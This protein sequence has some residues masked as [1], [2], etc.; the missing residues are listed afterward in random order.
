MEFL[1]T[2]AN[3]LYTFGGSNYTLC[4][5]NEVKSLNLSNP[6]HWRGQS[7]LGEYR[8]SFSSVVFNNTIYALGGVYRSFFEYSNP[9]IL[10][11]CERYD[12]RLNRWSFVTPMNVA[13]SSAAAA[14][15]G[16][17]IYVAGG[18]GIIKYKSLR[19]VERYDPQLDTWSEVAPMGTVRS[20]FA[21][22]AFAGRL[23]AT[24]GWD[25]LKE[26]STVESYDPV[27][28]SWQ[29]EA[30]LR[31][32][33]YGHSAID[34]YGELFVV[35]GCTNGYIFLKSVQ[36]T[37]KFVPSVGWVNSGK[38]QSGIIDSK[39]IMAYSSDIPQLLS[40]AYY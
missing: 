25:G 35:G 24:G 38:L 27:S 14:V 29:S 4:S 30:P 6:S 36:L 11:S 18:K 13:R 21:L 2:E 31:E 15:L 28:N 1:D 22:T 7:P 34:Y 3:L 23:W 40:G 12:N 20:A 26:L 32:A 5:T 16:N 39:L 10:S 33:R 9:W 37:E 19:S 17:Y 8:Q